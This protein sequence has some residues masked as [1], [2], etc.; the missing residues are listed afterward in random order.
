MVL[1][2]AVL[3]PI[4]WFFSD[5]PSVKWAIPW[6]CLLTNN[7]AVVSFSGGVVGKIKM[8]SFIC[9]FQSQPN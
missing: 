4:I 9:F 3:K 8:M 5:R 6:L 1:N 2:F 7:L